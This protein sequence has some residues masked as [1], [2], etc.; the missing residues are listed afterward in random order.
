MK[1]I[2]GNIELDV[3]GRAIKFGSVEFSPGEVE[4]AAE[5]ISL[6]RSMTGLPVLMPINN[7]K[8]E[9]RFN[10][11][12]TFNFVR[13]ATT[14][15]VEQVQP[16]ISFDDFDDLVVS[17]KDAIKVH[18]DRNQLSGEV[19]NYGKTEYLPEEPDIR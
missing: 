2:K 16:N 11:D 14:Q 3:T 15:T 7:E 10:G 4:K 18:I 19:R 17:L 9:I 6:A 13:T 1:L 5:L 8:F 12:K